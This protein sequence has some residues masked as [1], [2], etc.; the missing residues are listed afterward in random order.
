MPRFNPHHDA[1]LTVDR[2]I[3]LFR[4]EADGNL[5]SRWRY[6]TLSRMAAQV[7]RA[8]RSNPPYPCDDLIPIWDAIAVSYRRLHRR[9]LQ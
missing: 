9:N 1:C 6:V 3:E 2:A 8:Y 5:P 7:S 4:E